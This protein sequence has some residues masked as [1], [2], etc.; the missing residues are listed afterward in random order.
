MR[1]KVNEGVKAFF[2]LWQML[3]VI[4]Y[5]NMICISNIIF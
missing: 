5:K 3:Q 1:K 2:Y 4:V